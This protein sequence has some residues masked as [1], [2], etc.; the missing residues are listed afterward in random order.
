LELDK[1]IQEAIR[2]D[3]FN[4]VEAVSY[5]HTTH[6]RLNKKGTAADM[7]RNLKESSISHRAYDRLSPEERAG[8]TK[9]V[10]GVMHTNDN[11]IEYTRLYDQVIEN[12]S[13]T[14]R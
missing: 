4:I 10:R 13:R 8:N 6:G 7:M 2:R 12:A 14:V 1:Y 5:C 3:G 11:R 9:I